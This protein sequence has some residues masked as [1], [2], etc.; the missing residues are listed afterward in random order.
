M[1]NRPISDAEL[2][3]IMRPRIAE[4]MRFVVPRSAPQ[5]PEKSA[6]TGKGKEVPKQDRQSEQERD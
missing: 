6:A 2:S 3:E 4:L 1:N 5:E